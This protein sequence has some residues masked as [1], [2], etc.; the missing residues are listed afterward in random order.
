LG[1]TAKMRDFEWSE[2]RQALEIAV[3]AKRGYKRELLNK[4]LSLDFI[5]SPREA[6]ELFSTLEV[7]G[8]ISNGVTKTGDFTWKATKRAYKE[9]FPLWG[10]ITG[11][12][13]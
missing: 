12:F 6:E 7:L 3:S 9:I 8:Y 13:E 1:N 10:F 11:L 4:F 2:I 5:S